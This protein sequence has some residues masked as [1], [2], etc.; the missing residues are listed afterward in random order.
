MLTRLY[1]WFYIFP[2]IAY[3]WIY[4]RLIE[5][6]I[7]CNDNSSFQVKKTKTCGVNAFI[8]A[9]QILYTQHWVMMDPYTSRLEGILDESFDLR[10]VVLSPQT[11]KNQSI[12]AITSTTLVCQL[13]LIGKSFSFH[14]NTHHLYIFFYTFSY[15]SEHCRMDWIYFLGKKWHAS[16]ITMRPIDVY[17]AR[18]IQWTVESV[19]K[20]QSWD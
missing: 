8:W 3:S 16:K 14:Y 7:K 19:L 17:E 11:L 12:G 2:Y 4:E 18:L 5:R 10:G 20:K 13:Y 15:F 9:G 6:D 1:S